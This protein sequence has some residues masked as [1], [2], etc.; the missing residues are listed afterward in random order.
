MR[1]MHGTRNSSRRKELY[2]PHK[3]ALQPSRP[4]ALN[5]ALHLI[6]CLG[7][8]PKIGRH[9]LQIFFR[10]EVVVIAA[11]GLCRRVH[12]GQELGQNIIVIL[13]SIVWL[14]VHF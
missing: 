1:E 4:S 12:L 11:F 6:W 9:V 7:N 5:W 2:V 13:E 14:L 8:V 10:H 3:R